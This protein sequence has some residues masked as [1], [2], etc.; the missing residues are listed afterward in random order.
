M[1]SDERALL[2]DSD[3]S[4]NFYDSVKL[5]TKCKQEV[6][7]RIDGDRSLHRS[8]KK[9]P[10]THDEFWNSQEKLPVTESELVQEHR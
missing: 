5:T 4:S 8:I 1:E 9:K 7:S 10:P 6:G 2:A 3:G